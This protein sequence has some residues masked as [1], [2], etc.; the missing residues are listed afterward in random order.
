MTA[1]SVASVQTAGQHPGMCHGSLVTFVEDRDMLVESGS[2][3][4]GWSLITL[5]AA[6]SCSSSCAGLLG[7]WQPALT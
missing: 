5:K 1:G 3:A 6:V 4:A 2:H 7:A